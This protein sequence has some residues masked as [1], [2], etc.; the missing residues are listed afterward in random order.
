[1]KLNKIEIHNFLS[2][3]HAVVDFESYGNLVRIVGKNFDTKPRSSNGA[4]KSSIIEAVMFALFGKTIRKTND[5]SLVNYHT[6]GK[7]RVILTVNGD[8]VIERIKR[9]PMLSVTVGDENCTQESIQ[10]T[11]KYLEQ[12]LNINHQVFLASIVF[13]QGNTTD[14]L[15]ATPEEK[16][17]II[18]NFLSVGDLFKNRSTIKS[19]KS[20]YLQNKKINLT[21]LNDGSSKVDKLQA[22]LKKLRALKK[23]SKS[24][25]SS[26][27]YKFIFGKS[28]TEIQEQERAYHEKD[29][30]YERTVGHRDVLRD[31]ILQS[32]S[33]IKNL[34]DAPCEHCGKLSGNNWGKVQK[35]ESNMD[36][37]AT[38]E[39]EAVKLIRGL[40]KEVDALQI[41]VTVADFETIEQFKEIDTEVKIHT[42]QMRAEKKL[43]AKYGNLSTKAQKRYDIMKFWEHAFSEAGLIK[44]VIRNILDY[45]NERCNSYLST[46]SKGN[47]VIKFDD[48]LQ[49]LIYNNGAE[50]HFDS[51]SGGEK[52]RVS[53][54]VML[55]LNDLL[56]LTGK[57]RSN[58]IFFDE[59]ADS[60]DADG[61]KGLI[62][63]IHQLTKHKK[64]FLI[65]HNEYLTSLLEEYS[66]T[67]TVIKRNNLTKITK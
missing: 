49:E 34:K 30:E 40:G 7:C 28:L 57:D 65:T 14:F 2:I 42:K 16:R 19:L 52:K 24:Y 64:L 8:T 6:K 26:E 23:E 31:R 48:S 38:E 35:L 29:L 56:L 58:I 37:W 50:V 1:M 62:E 20:K 15:T 25:F 60:L 47:F 44:Y 61:V 3:K 53:L 22:R 46:L 51:L 9:A 11:Q 4:G 54:A 59:V 5:K 32:H 63:L 10:A 39:R 36:E 27:K 33:M 43:I 17:A 18:Q 45:L 55:G 41:P 66:E 21:L 67:L 13:G 12:I